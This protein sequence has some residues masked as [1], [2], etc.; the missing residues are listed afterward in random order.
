MRGTPPLFDASD[1]LPSNTGPPLTPRARAD[2]FD[3]DPEFRRSLPKF[4]GYL[5]D[6][7]TTRTIMYVCLVAK[8]TFLIL[9]RSF[10]A[11]LLLLADGNIFFVLMAAEHAL[12]LASKLLRGDFLYW[13]P[14]DGA[15]G[16]VVSFLL[17]VVVK[18]LADF[19]GMPQF[20]ASGESELR[21]SCGEGLC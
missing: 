19:T 7:G 11:A 18:A 4:Y 14:V 21:S 9:L 12:Y 1:S 16:L 15:S 17:R 5:P 2:D 6:D 20:R 13:L 8:S 3:S 10:A